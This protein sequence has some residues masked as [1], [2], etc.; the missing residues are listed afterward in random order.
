MAKIR[1]SKSD[2]KI[3]AFAIFVTAFLSGCK[4][5]D[6]GFAPAMTPPPTTSPS[7]VRATLLKNGSSLQT[8]TGWN[9]QV[10]TSDSVKNSVTANGWKIEVKYE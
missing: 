7:A 8:A 9:L 10:D 5:S 3:L 2:L 6:A 4:G 1:I